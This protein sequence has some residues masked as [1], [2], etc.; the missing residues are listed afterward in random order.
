MKT[1]LSTLFLLASA[2]TVAQGQVL[3]RVQQGNNITQVANG[4]TV[5][6]NSTGVAQP[7]TLVVTVT[8]TGTTSISFSQSPQ[9]LGSPDFTISRAPAGSTSL[10]PNQSLT[11]ELRYLPSSSQQALSEL[12]YPFTIAGA[13]SSDPS[14]PSTSTPGLLVLGLNGLTPEYSLNYSLSL[15][16]NVIGLPPNGVLP[17]TDTPVNNTTLASMALVNR[18]SGS[19]QVMSITT[20]GDAFSLVSLPLIP[21]QLAAGGGLQF[22]VRY[23]PRQ[24]GTDTGT[25]SITFEGGSTYTV[26]LRGRGI[27]SY[28]TYSLVPSSG[29]PQPLT[30]NQTIELPGAPVNGKSSV[31]IKIQNTSGL[32]ITVSSIAVTG[33][34]FQVSGLPFLPLTMPPGDTQLFTLTFAP[35]EVGPQSGRLR[36]GNDTFDLVGNQQ[37]SRLT[38]SYTGASGVTPL[39]PQ[40]S[41]IFPNLQVGRTSTAPFT[42]RNEGTAAAVVSSVA[43]LPPGAGKP[44]FTLVGL[45]A[46]PATIQPNETLS[47]TVQFAPTTTSLATATLRIDSDTFT[48]SG[49]GTTPDPLPSYTFQG[50]ASAQPFQQPTIGLTLASAYAVNL[51]GTLT[52]STASDI[53][54]DDPSVQ[55]VSGS[56]VANFTI[57]A[58]STTAVFAGGSTQIRFQTGSVAGTIFVTPAFATEGG[59]D[60]TPDKPKQFQVSLA[61][62]APQVLDLS[63]GSRTGTGFTLLL[64]GNTT[65]RSLSKITISFKGKPGYNFPQTEFSQ[66]L[67]TKS[68]VWFSSTS[69][70]AF[71]GQFQIQVPFTLTNSDSSSSATQPIQAIE[72][73]TVTVTNSVGA[74]TAVTVPVS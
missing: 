37:S 53:A 15:D 9:I 11:M 29:A 61:A 20:T 58:G 32:D 63:I 34:A 49:V 35:T 24:A 55:F 1:R 69:A 6:V 12:D 45:P 73:V 74:S 2:F 50:P 5:T 64:T 51:T 41:L 31:F 66:D 4:G 36:I 19:G 42:I 57:P 17:F 18:G 71:G 70:Q 46:L 10:G 3:I 21:T 33:A 72:S 48:L 59:L 39:L 62:T 8:Y 16:S 44:V 40:G 54:T 56:R 27:A 47:F 26:S 7:K 38:Y 22:Q 23:R 60:L 30:P 43:I 67:T 65:T 52:L 25:L 14:Q 13:A 68:Y 28:L